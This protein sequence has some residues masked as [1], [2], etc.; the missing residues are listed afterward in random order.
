MLTV[1][2][3]LGILGGA[4]GISLSARIPGTHSNVTLTGSIG[5]KE[6]TKSVLP[7]YAQATFGKNTNFINSSNAL[8]VWLA[9]GRQQFVVGKQPGA[10]AAGIEIK[11]KSK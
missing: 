9:Q 2:L 5:K 6:L 1:G 7:G 8:T 3:I 11:W 4:I 10:P